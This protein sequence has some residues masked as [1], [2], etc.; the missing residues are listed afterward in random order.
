[1]ARGAWSL[2]GSNHASR[3]STHWSTTRSP[4]AAPD[5]HEAHAFLTVQNYIGQLRL[6]SYADL[7]LLLVAMDSDASQLLA[8]SLLWFGFLIYLEWQHR[9]S[10]RRPWPAAAWIV[11]WLA[12]IAV[13]HTVAVAPF[14]LLSMVYAG[15]KAVPA[16]ACLSPL[17]SGGTKGSLLLLVPGV[18]AGQIMLVVVLTALRNV[19]GD[20]RDTLKDGREGVQTIPV[21]LG[22]RRDMP[23]AYPIALAATSAVWVLLGQ[24]PLWSLLAA[25]AIQAMTYPLTPR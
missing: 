13:S 9:D 20:L 15:K 5:P 24:L 19:V 16:V 6:Y 3:R 1:M 21:R 12:G 25:W 10:G 7:V 18:G 4:A 23:T 8:V 2:W 22:V 14:L 11:V 17:V